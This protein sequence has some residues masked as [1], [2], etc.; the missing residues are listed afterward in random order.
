MLCSYLAGV[1]APATFYM[2]L[3]TD[4]VVPDAD[5][6]TMSDLDEIPA[7]NGYTS[8][9]LAVARNTTDWDTRT[10]DDTGNT[11]L[12]QTKDLTWTASGGNLPP[13]G[14]GARYAVLTTDE[15]AVAD[16]QIVAWF[17]LGSNRI[18]TVGYDLTLQNCEVRLTE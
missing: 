10:E 18:M 8:G 11:G 13:S 5:T 6:N 15:A 12:A 4:S 14:T 9:G 2:A 3:V 7:G 17:N 1:A 16:R